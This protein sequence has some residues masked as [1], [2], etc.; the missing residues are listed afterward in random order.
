[1]TN[2]VL[3]RT[4]PPPTSPSS[5]VLMNSSSPV[6]KVAFIERCFLV[7]VG[8][9][10][11]HLIFLAFI[12]RS[13]MEV[14]NAIM[15]IFIFI[16]LAIVLIIIIVVGIILLT[17]HKKNMKKKGASKASK[18]NAKKKGAAK[19]ASSKSKGTPKEK[20]KASMT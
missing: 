3:T 18:D 15:T 7:S 4:P 6:S 10:S 9:V 5:H 11:S 1:M 20:P 2:F 17:Q 16:I 19:S 8:L 14:F 12:I 13:S